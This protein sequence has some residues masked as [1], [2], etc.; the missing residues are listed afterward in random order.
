MVSRRQTLLFLGASATLLGHD[1]QVMAGEP[2]ADPLPA[3][4]RWLM[5]LTESLPDPV[6]TVAAVEGKLP[7]QLSGTLYRNGPGIFE[8][9]GL[10]KA[11][12]LD[13]DGMIRAFTFCDGK[14]R[15]QARLVSTEKLAHEQRAARFLF[16]TWTTRAPGYLANVPA[17][18][19]RSQAGVAVTVKSGV[20]Y[21][22]D[23]VGWP[24]TLDPQ[25][26]DTVGVIDPRGGAAGGSP[27]S[28]KAHTKTDASTGAWVLTG[29]S[30][31]ARQQ[32]HS[33][34]ID[35]GGVSLTQCRTDNPRRDYFHDFFWTGRHVVFHLHP[36]PLSPMPMLLG[37]RAYA[38]CLSWR[39]ELGSLL[40]VVDPWGA[41]TPVTLEV[42]ATWMWH[43]VNAYEQGSSIIADFI[44]YEEPD[45]FLGP[46]AA[47]R[48]I[49][50]GH[51]GVASAPGLLRRITIDLPRRTARLETILDQNLEFPSVSPRVQGR[52]YRFA[53]CAIGGADLGWL[54]NGVAKID[55]QAGSCEQYRFG[56]KAYVG[57][58]VFVPRDDSQ[59]EDAGWLMCE[60]LDGRTERSSLAVFD[61]GNLREGPVAV[62]ELPHHLPFGLHGWWQ[63]A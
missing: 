16:P 5:R 32:L 28:Y 31:R 46:R 45:H 36:A 17:T 27:R 3:G 15:F 13:G 58:P 19:T 9:D 51:S 7:A 43:A 14:V 44:G 54:H 18:P 62:V 22:L 20:L 37:V 23:E 55:V 60:V 63:P 42:P 8:R 35:A 26:L 53:Y 11:T 34:L 52:A 38:D 12:L 59:A 49:M 57:E 48:A 1:G 21:A 50:T 2:K 4:E 56:E 61:A 29:T 25:T 10:R 6:D 41:Q 30:G 47:L 33:V 24:Y 39:P 40:Q